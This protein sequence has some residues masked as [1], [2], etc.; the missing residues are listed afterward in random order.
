MRQVEK[1]EHKFLTC[2]KNG[3]RV[4]L[5]EEDI[6]RKGLRESL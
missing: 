5:G 4:Y 3:D 1:G 2:P 6:K